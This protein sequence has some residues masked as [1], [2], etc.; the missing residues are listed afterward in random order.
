MKDD[1]VLEAVRKAR[2]DISRDL[3]NDPARLIAHYMNLQADFKGRLIQG[4]EAGD[5]GSEDTAQQGA[6]PDAYPSS[7]EARAGARR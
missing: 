7:P 3:G 5:D 6:A 2:C 4:P 1:P